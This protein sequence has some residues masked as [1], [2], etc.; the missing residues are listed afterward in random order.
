METKR[1]KNKVLNM[2]IL[3]TLVVAVLF[4]TVTISAARFSSVI[5][6]DSTNRGAK[7]WVKVNNYEAFS[8]QSFIVNLADTAD[9]NENVAE[10]TV[11][12]GSSGTLTFLIDCTSCEVDVVY[13][14]SIDFHDAATEYPNI[15]FFVGTSGQSDYQEIE[16]GETQIS[17]QIPLNV[18]NM[19]TQSETVEINWVWPVD[20]S[21]NESEF[22]GKDFQFDV[23]IIA[24]QDQSNL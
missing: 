12:P 20:E 23:T 15:M 22:A 21:V 4:A 10:G 9:E 3:A 8:T 19:S 7:W 24:S 1:T 11:A 18:E 13:T 2:C 17:G 6:S 5:S 14:L 16:I